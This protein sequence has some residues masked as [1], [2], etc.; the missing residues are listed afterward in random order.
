VATF[1]DENLESA[2]RSALSVGESADLTCSL[3]SELTDLVAAEAEI[4]SL[5]GIQ[6]LTGLEELNLPLL[7]RV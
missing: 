2:V 7:N 4:E 3:V 1:E 5:D 6:N